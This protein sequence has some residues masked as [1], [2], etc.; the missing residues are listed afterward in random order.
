[1]SRSTM[2]G[3]TVS[4]EYADAAKR[5]EYLR[6]IDPALGDPFAAGPGGRE[7]ALTFLVGFANDSKQVAVFQPGNVALLPDKGDRAFPLDMTDLYMSAERAGIEDLQQVIDRSSRILFDSST[8]IPSGGR[9]T[10]LI[11]FRTIEGNWRQLQ[12]LFSYIQIGS[13]THTLSFPFHKE[14][15]GG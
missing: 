7:R 13:E 12:I 3:L 4:V 6:S 8:S 2:F 15:I 14:P 11:A 5:I 9:V 10:R 1:M